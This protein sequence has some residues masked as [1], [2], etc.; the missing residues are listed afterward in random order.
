MRECEE[1]EKKK[2]CKPSPRLLGLPLVQRQNE[3][4]ARE[5]E[6]PS[7]EASEAEETVQEKA[8]STFPIQ[9]QGGEGE[10][11]SEPE[12]QEEPASLQ[13]KVEGPCARPASP[14]LTARLQ[15]TKGADSTS[16]P[17]PARKWKA[18]SALT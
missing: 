18:P 17:I 7:G 14:S 3:P 11:T 6:E 9:R 2:N 8:D 13:T 5:E 4:G 10:D 1:K 12:E 16:P 15:A